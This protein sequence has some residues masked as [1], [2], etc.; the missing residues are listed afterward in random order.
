[1]RLPFPP[2]SPPKAPIVAT[3]AKMLGTA[4]VPSRNVPYSEWIAANLE[5]P[6]RL[7]GEA[8]QI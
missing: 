8:P 2:D 3:P 7:T 6:S 1:M 4:P 5:V